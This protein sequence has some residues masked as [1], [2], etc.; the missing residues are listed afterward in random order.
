MEFA[1]KEYLLLLLLLVPYVLWY[2][3]RNR[4]K[5]PT[6]RM[7]DTYAYEYGRKSFKMK[8]IHLPIFLRS[9][10]FALVVMVLARPQ[11]HQPLSKDYSNGINIMLAMDVST[12]MLS[13]D[14]APNR[15][16]VAKDVANEFISSRPTDNIGLTIFAGEAFTQCPMTTDH[17]SLTNLLMNIRPDISANGLIKDGTAIG[18]GLANAISR[19]KNIKAKSK[20]IILLTDGSNNMGDISPKTA[21]EIAKKFG[22]R[23]YTIGLG[24]DQPM[25]ASSKTVGEIDYNTLQ[26]IAVLTNGEFYRAQSRQELSQIYK[27]I[28]KLEKTKIENKNYG[29][30]YEA[31]MP[32]AFF[33]L[34]IFLMEILLRITVLKRIP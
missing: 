16:E 22:I 20:V 30:R 29:K 18:M 13:Q 26:E 3:L 25:D 2:F 11:T 1:N 8:I 4:G 34:I 5:E 28:D 21:A 24:G 9:L 14:V 7:A 12:S 15:M 31:Y 27:D 19:L 33:A 10:T 32:F 23:I 6:L 17:V